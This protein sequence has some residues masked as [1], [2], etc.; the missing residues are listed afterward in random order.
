[1]TRAILFYNHAVHIRLQATLVFK[2]DNS[3][4]TPGSGAFKADNPCSTPGPE[5]SKSIF[6][7][8]F[9]QAVF[10]IYVQFGGIK[11][12]RESAMGID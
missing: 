5:A 10:T 1:M 9:F 6:L 11:M 4:S 7:S 8:V 2:A 12:A 3:G